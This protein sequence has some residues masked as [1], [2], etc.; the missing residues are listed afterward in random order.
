MASFYPPRPEPN[1]HGG[2]QRAVEW[3][4]GAPSDRL[5]EAERL[6]PSRQL[7]WIGVGGI[8]ILLTL[9]ALGESTGTTQAGERLAFAMLGGYYA[10]ISALLVRAPERFHLLG[11]AAVV[12]FPIWRS[13]VNW[14]VLTQAPAAQLPFIA[15]AIAPWQ[16]VAFVLL[17]LMC[18]LPV[19]LWLCGPAFVLLTVSFSLPL[20]L[21]AA[22]PGRGLVLD[23]I[24]YTIVANLNALAVMAGFGLL[25]QKHRTVRARVRHL[26]QAATTD[27]LTGLLSRR[28]MR[29]AL[30]AT[31]GPTPSILSAVSDRS[32]GEPI[33]LPACDAL[34]M[35]DLDG[36]KSINDRHGH[37]VGDQVIALTGAVLRQV[38]QA[39]P[40]VLASRWGGEE[41]LL[42]CV[43]HDA[44]QARALSERLRRCMTET[45]WPHGLVVTASFGVTT[46]RTP[47][48]IVQAIAEVDQMLYRAKAGGR[49]CVVCEPDRA[50][51]TSGGTGAGGSAH[52]DGRQAVVPP[53]WQAGLS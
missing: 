45:A 39:D 19:A 51:G 29:E 26:E 34:I 40:R 16:P 48:S 14:L 17:F 33:A 44:E 5:D 24:V 15:S 13:V 3:I 31:N 8:A 50:P 27:P 20:W 6:F 21:G 36:F 2:L 37:L 43:G 22:G 38:A 1:L 41:F 49:N 23:L 12:P 42:L 32:D 10:V 46:V 28:A 35:L 52:K 53:G 7:G 30:A 4:Q 47:G 18:R 25:R 9:L 11:L